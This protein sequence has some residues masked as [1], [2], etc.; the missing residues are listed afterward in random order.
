MH[1]DFITLKET[2]TM[3]AFFI[4]FISGCIVFPWSQMMLHY[5]GITNQRVLNVSSKRRWKMLVLNVNEKL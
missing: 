4:F 2:G 1:Q 3:E 5:F